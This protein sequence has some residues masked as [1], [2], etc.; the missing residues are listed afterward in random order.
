VKSPAATGVTVTEPEVA[1]APLQ[2]PPA[3][4]LVA[5]AED[6]LRVVVWAVVMLA[7]A[8]ARLTVGVGGG[9]LT[10]TLAE[11]LTLPQVRV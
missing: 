6:Q 9:E 1:L 4:Q 11:L 8:N 3:V 7:G 10:V 5:L 2:A